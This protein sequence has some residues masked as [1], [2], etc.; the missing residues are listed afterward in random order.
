MK[1][2]LSDLSRFV[3][4]VSRRESGCALALLL[5][6]A[7]VLC[8]A[9]TPAVASGSVPASLIRSLPSGTTPLSVAVD[10]DGNL[11]IAGDVALSGGDPNAIDAFVAKLS[12]GGELTYLKVFGGSSLDIATSVA[13][14]DGGNVYVTGYT[15]SFDF[16]TTKGAWQTVYTS[17]SKEAFALKLK[18][19]G[20]MAYSTL[21][22]GYKRCIGLGNSRE[23]RGRGRY[24]GRHF[25][26]FSR[27]ARGDQTT[28]CSENIRCTVE[29]SRRSGDLL[30]NRFGR[31]H[32][33]RR[34]PRADLYCRNRVRPG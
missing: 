10:G 21:V 11:L 23:L 32:G 29:R 19:D 17:S 28:S 25:R 26:R 8:A 24:H 20:E 1:I 7:G 27:H 31:T 15:S 12:R 22:G 5:F 2:L 33:R 9:D 16:P 18:P 4:T 13:V 14:D 3:P 30:C 6:A 34:R